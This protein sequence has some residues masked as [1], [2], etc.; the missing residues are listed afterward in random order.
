MKTKSLSVCIGKARAERSV[1][2]LVLGCLLS[3]TP[4]VQAAPHRL[5]ILRHGEKANGYA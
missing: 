3:L 5:I 1:A 2:I 4:I